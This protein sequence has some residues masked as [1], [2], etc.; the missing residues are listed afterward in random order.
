MDIGTFLQRYEAWVRP[1][2]LAFRCCVLLVYTAPL[3]VVYGMII[4]LVLGCAALAGNPGLI[5]K[6]FFFIIDALPWYAQ[7]ATSS[8]YDAF[9]LE[10]K[11]RMR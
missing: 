5:V 10:L 4:Y 8:I 11:A 7:H 6:F 2:R 9:A 1:Y 3:V